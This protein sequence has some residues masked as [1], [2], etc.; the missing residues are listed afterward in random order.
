MNASW[1]I[2]KAYLANLYYTQRHFNMALET[3]NEVYEV[4]A[5]FEAN[6]WFTEQAFPVLLST[7]WT[8]VYDAELQALLGLC[9]L[10]AF[11]SNRTDVR[12]ACLAVCPVLFVLYLKVRCAYHKNC[13]ADAERSFRDFE[14]HDKKCKSSKPLKM[15]VLQRFHAGLRMLRA[16]LQLFHQ[17]YWK[18]TCTMPVRRILTE[19]SDDV[20]ERRN[21]R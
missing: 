2:A 13:A 5:I 12:S 15:R 6:Q 21:R 3:C 7:Q 9:S 11:V 14:A 4:F 8:A 17:A 18:R 10:C 16:S 1:F 19:V 20:F